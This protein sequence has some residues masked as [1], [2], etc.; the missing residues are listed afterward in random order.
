MFLDKYQDH[1]G[2]WRFSFASVRDSVSQTQRIADNSRKYENLKSVPK[3]QH[4]PE[5]MAQMQKHPV[6]RALELEEKFN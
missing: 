5:A 6:L 4:H 3:I 1:E 2:N